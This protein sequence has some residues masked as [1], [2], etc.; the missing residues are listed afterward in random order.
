MPWYHSLHHLSP[1]PTS[2]VT[3]VVVALCF[4]LG[5]PAPFAQQSP[6][7]FSQ[8]VV[9]GDSYSDTGN[10]RARVIA[11]T[12]GSVDFPSHSFNYSTGRYTN[13]DA[14]TPS[15]ASYAGLWHEQLATFL[16]LPA[17]TYS[18]GGGTDYAFGGATTKDGTAEVV[19][20]STP[21]GDVT[22]TID[23][24]GKQLD[25]YLATHA[26][27]PNALYVLW[28]G[29]NDL[30]QDNS[31]ASVTA[32]AA[33]V[34]A[35]FGRLAQ[36]GA[37]F[38]MVPNLPA[39]GGAPAFPGAS[40][41][42]KALN[43][44][45]ANYR[46]ALSASLAS[47]QATL[48]S[49]GF[50]PALYPVDV[51]KETIRFYSDPGMFGFTDTSASAQGNSAA[52]PDHFFYWDGLHPTTAGHHWIAKAA[53]DAITVPFT[54][55]ARALNLATRVFVDTGERVSIA[56]FI[57]AG[58]APKKVLIRGIGPSLAANGVPGPLANPTLTLFDAAGNVTMTND[59]WK[60]SPD[61][62]EI[63]NTGIPP[64]NDLE[65]A[66]IANLAPGQYTARLAGKDGGAGNGL[67][68]VYDL[69]SGAGSTLANL[70]TRGF[71]SGGDNVLIGGLIIGNGASPIIV[72]RALGPSLGPFG[73]LI[74]LDDPT[75]ELH[76]GNGVTIAFDDDWKTPSSQP[77]RAANLAPAHDHESAIVA[78]FLT[79]GNYTAIVRDKGNAT[80]VALVEA[81]R[82]P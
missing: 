47:T 79:P 36:A 34:A 53:Y 33:R 72:L 64:H 6:P 68:E 35:L 16:N 1:R 4:F 65:S 9:F 82:I 15:S 24:I 52:N 81:Y 32:T 45:I 44:A 27:D 39:I 57:I 3:G 2:H 78:P 7:P 49:Q 66:I 43:A 42:A 19:V 18:L 48:A 62:A 69:Q 55:P 50:T 28:G 80:G 51:W 31:G 11:K 21:S 71:V 22:V 58:D 73:V 63:M 41:Q 5:A 70:S 76:D 25:D 26:V 20:L 74:F 61:A 77:L 8:I 54:S 37:R 46:S 59:D 12:G 10:L 29:I 56:G 17:A 23:H 13:D 14:T 30:L 75:I 60:N 38:I 67:V 40:D